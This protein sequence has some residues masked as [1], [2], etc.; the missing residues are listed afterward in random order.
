MTC[1]RILSLDMRRV[2]SRI[3]LSPREH[4]TEVSLSVEDMS[5]QRLQTLPNEFTAPV[6]SNAAV[7]FLIIYHFFACYLRFLTN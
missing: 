1:N 4:R 2:A 6:Y 5:V 3:H 7:V